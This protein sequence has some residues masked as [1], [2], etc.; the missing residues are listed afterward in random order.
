MLLSGAKVRSNTT[1]Q[2]EGRQDRYERML[3]QGHKQFNISCKMTKESHVI[4]MKR[5]ILEMLKSGKRISQSEARKTFSHYLMR[6]LRR[7]A[8]SPEQGDHIEVVLKFL[9]K[10]SNYLRTPY[11]V[12]TPSSKMN[13]K[14]K[15]A[16]VAKQLNDFLYLYNRE[17]DL[18]VDKTERPSQIPTKL[19]NEFIDHAR[20]SDL[21]E[22]LI[23]QTSLT[24]PIQSN[25]FKGMIKCIPNTPTNAYASRRWPTKM[26]KAKT[27]R[28]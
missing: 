1:T 7:I 18:F 11:N 16:I 25:G 4:E 21:E 3:R 20:E 15:T 8:Q 12:K 2:L 10:A 17:T 23:Y 28:V 13:L 19:Y 14:D 6:I 26:T 24:T 27:V 5:K 22:V 9:Q